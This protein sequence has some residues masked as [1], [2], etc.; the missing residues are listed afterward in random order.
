M[1]TCLYAFYKCKHKKRF[2]SLEFSPYITCQVYK[3]FTKLNIIYEQG[4]KNLFLYPS[5]SNK[6]RFTSSGNSILIKYPPCKTSSLIKY[7]LKPR[8]MTWK[9]SDC[10]LS[11]MT[12]CKNWGRILNR[13]PQS[14]KVITGWRNSRALIWY[15]KLRTT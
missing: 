11:M 9:K 2:A 6:R 8:T 5:H 3:S 7:K 1:V 4:F 12:P 14:S 10:N 15:S 13:K